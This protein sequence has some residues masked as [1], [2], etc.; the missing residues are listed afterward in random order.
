MSP[1]RSTKPLF[2]AAVACATLVA[3]AGAAA[4]DDA[5][6]VIAR[7]RE[8]IGGDA[9]LAAVHSI[10]FVGSLH[11]PDG[12]VGDIEIVVRLPMQQHMTVTIDNVRETTAL[13]GYDGW[14]RM[15]HLDTP[16]NWDLQLLEAEQIR[17]LRANTME[18][19]GFYRGFEKLDGRVEPM[20]EVEIE[21]VPCAKL[22]FIYTP[23]IQFMRCFDLA[24]GRLVL[25][26]V[27]TGESVRESGEIVV[28]GV[29]FPKELVTTTRAGKRTINFSRIQVNE[30]F[31][32]SL[33]DVPLLVPGRT[34]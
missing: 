25:S 21:G 19:I 11:L 13:S 18:T 9:A 10:R 6:A 24:T 16:A 8:F 33:F 34:P 12:R 28:N 14:R 15:E 7:A 4:A 2:W 32:D 1:L 31:P 5:A 29:R 26:Q 27:N 23:R 17:Q 3:P 20:G 30:E 22:A